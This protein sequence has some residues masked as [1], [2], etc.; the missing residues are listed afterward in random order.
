LFVKAHAVKPISPTNKPPGLSRVRPHA[1]ATKSERRCPLGGHFAV[2]LILI[3][4]RVN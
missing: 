2:V 4:R 1:T 3:K